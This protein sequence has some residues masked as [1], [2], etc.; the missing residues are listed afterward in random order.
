MSQ[1]NEE[2]SRV[3]GSKS[4]KK[5][6]YAAEF[7]RA[8]V[9]EYFQ[10]GMGIA[11]FSQKAGIPLTTL[12]DWVEAFKAAHPTIANSAMTKDEKTRAL[13]EEVAQLKRELVQA[14]QECQKA[15]ACAHTWETMVDVAEKMYGIEIKKKLAPNNK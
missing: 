15:R 9:C 4:R 11:A 13:E 1:K 8:K 7:K 6:H 3:S 10:S 12:N 14:T 5:T 2:L